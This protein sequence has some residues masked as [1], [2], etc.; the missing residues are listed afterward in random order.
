MALTFHLISYRTLSGETGVARV[1]TDRTR[2]V[3]SECREQIPGFLSG[4][5]LG[6]EPTLTLT[7][8]TERG[9]QTKTVSRTLLNRSVGRLVARAADRGEAWNIAVVDE[10]GEDVT[11]SVPCFA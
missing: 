7:Y 10:R 9:T 11:D 6:P 3:R 2:P 8:E 1:G 4:S 5:H